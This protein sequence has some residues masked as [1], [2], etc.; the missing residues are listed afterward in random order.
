[1]LIF[2]YFFTVVFYCSS[3]SSRLLGC[4]FLS[5]SFS[6]R[7]FYSACEGSSSLALTYTLLCTFFSFVSL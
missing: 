6:H 2:C 5:F 4:S 3:S 7:G 1:M